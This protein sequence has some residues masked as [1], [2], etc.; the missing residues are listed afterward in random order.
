MKWE[1]FLAKFGDVGVVDSKEVSFLF[2]SKEVMQVQFSRWVRVGRL[3]KVR[4]GLYLIPEMFRKRPI[5][6]GY[7]AQR[8]VSPSY[9]SL[10]KA[11]EFYG[12]IPER[13]SEITSLTTRR[14]VRYEVEGRAYSYRHISVRLFWGYEVFEQDGQKGFI[15]LPEKA[16]LDLFYFSHVDKKRAFDFFEEMRFDNLQILNKE[17]L[18]HFAS[19]WGEKQ[20]YLAEALLEYADKAGEWESL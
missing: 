4:R 20:L 9:V 13:V 15:A 14:P 17:R 12:I 8:I 16:L 19:M 3:I 1:E 6:W 10:E 7:L 18:L 2:P 11:L 5:F